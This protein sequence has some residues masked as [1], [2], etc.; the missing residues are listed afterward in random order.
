MLTAGSRI[1]G[2]LT[3]DRKIRVFLSQV[4]SY[5]DC[6]DPNQKRSRVLR[7]WYLILT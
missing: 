2:R 1:V 4:L 3:L 6:E 7:G 5:S